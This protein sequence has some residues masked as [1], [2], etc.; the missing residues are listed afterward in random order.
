ML[1]DEDEEE[2]EASSPGLLLDERENGPGKLSS[3]ES[4]K[5]GM[6]PAV[7]MTVPFYNVDFG[8]F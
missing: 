7:E 4:E 2:E 5:R 3:M 8:A 1:E 6:K